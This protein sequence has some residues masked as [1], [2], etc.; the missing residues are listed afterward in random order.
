MSLQIVG[1]VFD[2]DVIKALFM[3]TIHASILTTITFLL[4]A[5][6]NNKDQ[7][8]DLQTG[9]TITVEKDSSTG[10]MINTETKKPVEIY[11]NTATH[12]TIYG[13]TGKVINNHVTKH[14]NGSYSYEAD[15]DVNNVNVDNG[16]YKTKVQRDGDI[17]IKDGD[18][19]IKIE[20]SGVEK[21]KSK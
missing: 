8:V 18:T 9:K 10:Y 12:D 4:L 1:E 14:P 21:V 19:K 13:K 11:V 7:Y 17:K 5:A 3:K 20:T 15:V 6:C 2:L 16:D